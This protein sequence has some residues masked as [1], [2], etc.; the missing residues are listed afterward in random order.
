MNEDVLT[1]ELTGTDDDK[2]ITELVIK[3]LAVTDILTTR[4]L[5][6]HLE[7]GRLVR[8][9]NLF[10]RHIELLFHLLLSLYTFHSF[11]L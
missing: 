7:N 10:R 1:L 11:S 5:N 2:S 6:L 9:R 8:G 4:L 3:P